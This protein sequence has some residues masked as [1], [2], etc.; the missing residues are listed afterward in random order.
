MRASLNKTVSLLTLII[1]MMSVIAYH[2]NAASF[3]HELDHE[4]HTFE[5]LD[6]HFHA[7]LVDHNKPTSKPLSDSDHKLLHSSG[8]LQPF[9]TS[10]IFDGSGNLVLPKIGRAHV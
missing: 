9:L 7:S 2:F 6:N 4:I 8:H 5:K 3:A 1:F 10:F